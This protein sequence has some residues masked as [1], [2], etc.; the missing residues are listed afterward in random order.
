MT[1][2]DAIAASGLAS[3]AILAALVQALIEKFVLTPE[4]TREIY[5]AALLMIEETQSGGTE[6]ADVLAMAREV[7]E[8]HLRA[9]GT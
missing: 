6:A 2:M 8:E 9:E 4:E 7:I 3:A 5:E 1:E